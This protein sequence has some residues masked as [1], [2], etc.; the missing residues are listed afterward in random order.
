M[1]NRSALL[2]ALISPVAPIMSLPCM[3]ARQRLLQHPL[4]AFISSPSPLIVPRHSHSHTLRHNSTSS[5]TIPSSSPPTSH[6]QTIFSG[7]Q[8][9]GIPHLGNY[10]GALQNWVRLQN[11]ADVTR[12]DR[13][14]YSVVDL[15][16]ITMK[17][18]K[19]DLRRWKRESLASLL[20]VG[21]REELGSV[22]FF[23]SDVSAQS[24]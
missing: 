5:P 6:P 22:L 7:I 1:K 13:L 9:T 19:G 8:P 4:R 23:Q 17:Q 18:E 16:A 14:L 21:L 12:G 20:A 3:Q 15:H 10:L 24:E 11:S 2:F